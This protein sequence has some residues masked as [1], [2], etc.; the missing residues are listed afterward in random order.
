MLL[1]NWFF[2]CCLTLGLLRNFCSFKNQPQSVID[3]IVIGEC[4]GNVRFQYNHVFTYPAFW[5]KTSA[6]QDRHFRQV[7]LIF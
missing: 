3:C 7:I 6:R 4:F 5:G 1:V 2:L